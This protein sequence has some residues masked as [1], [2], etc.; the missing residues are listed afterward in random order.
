[1]IG[2]SDNDYYSYMYYAIGIPILFAIYNIP[3]M[4]FT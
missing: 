1:M 4:Y 3:Y 2:N